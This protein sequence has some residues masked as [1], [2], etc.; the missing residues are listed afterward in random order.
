MLDN[1]L[2]IEYNTSTIKQGKDAGRRKGG[3]YE[4]IC[5]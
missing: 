2:I 1:I 5:V 4:K 3:D